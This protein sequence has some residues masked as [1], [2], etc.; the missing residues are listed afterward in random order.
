MKPKTKSS[1]RKARQPDLEQGRSSKKESEIETNHDNPETLN[2][3]G[4]G[5][6]IK[7]VTCIDIWGNLRTSPR[8][9]GLEPKTI[10]ELFLCLPARPKASARIVLIRSKDPELFL[11]DEARIE[12][13]Y[14]RQKVERLAELPQLI[15]SR[16][17]T[18]LQSLKP[19]HGAAI[20][21][22]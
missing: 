6:S 3:E 12:L 22:N 2:V 5:D 14:E 19:L 13:Q 17:R 18:R 16:R 8:I 4:E 10:D 9:T 11:G 15:F 1:R 7:P 21:T 20:R